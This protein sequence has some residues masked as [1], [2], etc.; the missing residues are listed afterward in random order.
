MSVVFYRSATQGLAFFI[1]LNVKNMV[2]KKGMIISQHAAV[3]FVVQLVTIGR[4]R[5]AK[6]PLNFSF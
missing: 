2:S 1:L 6:D 3:N 4:I 5:P